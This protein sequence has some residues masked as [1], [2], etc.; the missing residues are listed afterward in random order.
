RRGGLRSSSILPQNTAD[1]T[2]EQ[3][4]PEETSVQGGQA[5][6]AVPAADLLPLP[7]LGSF[8]QS[9]PRLV[10]AMQMQAQAFVALQA[11]N[12]NVVV[13]DQQRMADHGRKKDAS[14]MVRFKKMGP[15]LFKGE[16]DPDIVESWIR[17]TEKIFTAIRCPEEDKV[18]VATFT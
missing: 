11:Q 17:E 12:G 9:F 15:P 7:E 5:N 16:S 6:Q 14:T 8:L 2:L 3:V 4:T 18:V 13:A 10:D 1:V